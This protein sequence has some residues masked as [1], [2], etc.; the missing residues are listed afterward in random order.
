MQ[1]IIVVGLRSPESFRGLSGTFR[2]FQGLSGTFKSDLNQV[3]KNLNFSFQVLSGAFRC[4]QVLSDASGMLPGAF[5]CFQ[6]LS[7]AFQVLSGAF[8]FFQD[9]KKFNFSKLPESP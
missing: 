3:Q 8:R 4:V 9:I 1:R 7:G 5:R 2:D 6:V